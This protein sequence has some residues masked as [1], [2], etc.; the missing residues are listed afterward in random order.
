LKADM[1]RTLDR[2]WVIAAVLFA[3]AACARKAQDAAPAG[4]AKPGAVRPEVTRE[5][6]R[7][8]LEEYMHRRGD[9]CVDKPSWPIDVTELDRAQGTRDARQLPVLAGLGVVEGREV[10]V[11]SKDAPRGA[12]TRVTR[13]QLTELGRRSYIDRRTRKPVDPNDED[14]QPDLCVARLS[15]A[16][17]VSWELRPDDKAPTSATVSY[18]YEV[19]A[20]AWMR[21]PEAG[22]VFPAVARV[23]AGAREAT[24]T[25]GF[26]LTPAGW[27]ANELVARTK[28]MASRAGAQG[29]DRRP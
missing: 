6:F 17:V 27:V 9:L 15:L 23:L 18:T 14:A 1:T 28:A 20:P 29:S 26:T 25:E 16:D 19:A 13:Y 3:G 11:R 22:R 10:A 2:R 5:G 24:L 8:G 7:A 21:D 12:S 4:G